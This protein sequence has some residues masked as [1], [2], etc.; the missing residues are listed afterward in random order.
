MAAVLTSNTY[1]QIGCFFYPVACKDKA[2]QDN[3]Q[4][5]GDE[6]EERAFNL[7]SQGEKRKEKKFSWVGR[8]MNYYV[9]KPPVYLYMTNALSP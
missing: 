7:S 3:S 6:Q 8:M 2:V 9:G 5:K 4:T 1:D